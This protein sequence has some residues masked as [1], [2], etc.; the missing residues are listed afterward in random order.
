M[1]KKKPN[2]SEDWIEAQVNTKVNFH[3]IALIMEEWAMLAIIIF[4]MLV[5]TIS[6]AEFSRN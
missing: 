2:L 6:S 4:Y 3:L 5:M 1:M